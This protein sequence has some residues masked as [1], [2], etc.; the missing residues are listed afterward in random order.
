MIA[1]TVRFHGFGGPEVLRFEALAVGER[2][3]D[4]VRAPVEAVGVTRAVT[5]TA[6]KEAALRKAGAAHVVVLERG[7]LEA[8]V[9]RITD[10]K[11]AK[12]AFDPIGGPIVGSLAAAMGQRGML[13]L[14]GNLSGQAQNT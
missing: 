12:L 3:A 14:Y 8:E 6:A 2:A 7:A 1:K 4:A 9:L 11:G 13:V 5:W 10:G